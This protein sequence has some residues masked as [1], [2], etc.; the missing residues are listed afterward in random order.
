[1]VKGKIKYRIAIQ[2]FD[3]TGEPKNFANVMIKTKR[4]LHIV[5]NKINELFEKE[6]YLVKT[7][8]TNR[9]LE[10]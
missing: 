7:K 3:V 5:E 6:V 8:K 9:Q 4:D 10:E 1:M 2:Q